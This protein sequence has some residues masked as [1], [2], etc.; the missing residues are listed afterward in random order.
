MVAAVNPLHPAYGSLASDTIRALHEAEDDE[1]REAR[2]AA[3]DAMHKM[4]L[5]VEYA[6]QCGGMTDEDAETIAITCD[7]FGQ[8]EPLELVLRRMNE[9][10]ALARKAHLTRLHEQTLAALKDGRT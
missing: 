9:R 8:G 4:A 10:H 2:A 5:A 6:R 3:L 1:R 7:E